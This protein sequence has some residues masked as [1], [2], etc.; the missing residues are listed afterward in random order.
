MVLQQ[1]REA[2]TITYYARSI[3][4]EAGKLIVLRIVPCKKMLILTNE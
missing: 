2:T 4:A 3:F 1:F